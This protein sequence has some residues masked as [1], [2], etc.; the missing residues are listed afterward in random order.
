[1]DQSASRG[2][3]RVT[4]VTPVTRWGT[5]HQVCQKSLEST[6][7][8][9]YR[10]KVITTTDMLKRV[11]RFVVRAS[12]KSLEGQ[13]REERGYILGARA[14]RVRREGIST[15]RRLIEVLTIG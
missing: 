5:L 3:R 12:T 13:S 4:P 10:A 7:S 2:A 1:M 9:Q 15:R 8:N 14:N 11:D 6:L